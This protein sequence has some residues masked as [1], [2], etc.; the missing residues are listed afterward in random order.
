MLSVIIIEDI[1]GEYILSFLPEDLTIIIPNYSHVP[2]SKTWVCT[3][4]PMSRKLPLNT[5]DDH[6]GCS[7]WDTVDVTW[8][9]EDGNDGN[10][11]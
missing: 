3:F 6:S 9:P 4:V 5:K 1:N 7:V 8:Q 10:F 11:E 2:R